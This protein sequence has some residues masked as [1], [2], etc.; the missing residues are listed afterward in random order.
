MGYRCVIAEELLHGLGIPF[1][2]APEP[3]QLSRDA[4]Q[5]YDA[6]PDEAGGR[7]VA[8]DD[9]LKDRREQFLGVEPL[10][11]HRGR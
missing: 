10:V 7:V 1:G 6:V 2:M 3:G 11:V 8:G 4:K 9:E 5:G